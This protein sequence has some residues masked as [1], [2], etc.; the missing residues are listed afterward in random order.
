MSLLS[1]LPFLVFLILVVRSLCPRN[2]RISSYDTAIS[3]LQKSSFEER[4]SANKSLHRAFGISNPFVIGDKFFH[5]EYVKLVHRR[6]TLKTRD[7]SDIIKAAKE[8]RN[9]LQFTAMQEIRNGVR[10]MVMTISLTILGVSGYE[11]DGLLRV[12]QLIDTIWTLAKKGNETEI[13]RQELYSIIRKWEGDS[14]INNLA[15]ISN[16]PHERAILSILIPAYET[17]YRVALPALFHAH[18]TI[19][20]TPFLESDTGYQKLALETQV[21]YSYLALIQETLRRYPVVKRLKR[22]NGGGTTSI[23]VEGIHHEGWE[24]SEKFD[25]W[26]W[27]TGEK[28]NFMAFGAGRGRCI[29]NELVVGMVIGIVI[30][31]IEDE[32]RTRFDREQLVEL[33]DNGRGK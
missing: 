23:D 4:A 28:G 26:R 8:T 32:I 12:G 19:T 20:F 6:L 18:G 9:K 2:Q 16:V 25:P 27:M 22:A 1:L 17:M 7:W 5:D 30:A 31:F 15:T 33:V 10:A 11:L 13:E 21:G 3:F 14:F 29:A 24:D